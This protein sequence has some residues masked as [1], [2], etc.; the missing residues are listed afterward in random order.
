[1]S[2]NLEDEDTMVCGESHQIDL[3]VLLFVVVVLVFDLRFRAAGTFDVKRP[4]LTWA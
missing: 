2:D 1:M 3:L 4:G